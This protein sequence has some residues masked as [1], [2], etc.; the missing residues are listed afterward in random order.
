MKWKCLL[1]SGQDEKDIFDLKS[2]V[3]FKLLYVVSAC[4]NTDWYQILVWEVYVLRG[5][6]NIFNYNMV[7]HMVSANFLTW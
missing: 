4:C 7:L 5:D 6:G 2:N 3:T 1:L